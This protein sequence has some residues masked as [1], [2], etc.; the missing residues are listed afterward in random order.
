MG[1]LLIKGKDLRKRKSHKK[2]ECY[3]CGAHET[4]CELHHVIP[5]EECAF[6]MNF[7]GK[8]SIETPVVSLCP[9]HH[10]Y[11]HKLLNN[12][13]LFASFTA[14][15]RGKFLKLWNLRLESLKRV[16]HNEDTNG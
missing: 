16:I 15:E 12:P 5:Y 11:I 10:R 3:V 2:Q 1:R 4:I 9:N 7:L 6:Y 14:K 13:L 8:K